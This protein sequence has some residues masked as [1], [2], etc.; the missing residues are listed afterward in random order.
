MP[1]QLF[2][3][4]I[5]ATLLLIFDAFRHLR[6]LYDITLYATPGFTLKICYA[7]LAL[8]MLRD[9][10]DYFIDDAAALLLLILFH[11]C[12]HLRF[13]FSCRYRY[14]A[15]MLPHDIIYAFR[16]LRCYRHYAS[17]YAIT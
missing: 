1:R 2:D 17:Y 4:D 5:F 6:Q 3:I 11:S 15:M 8:L 12:R 9:D 13:H 16:C 7:L 14:A 10:I